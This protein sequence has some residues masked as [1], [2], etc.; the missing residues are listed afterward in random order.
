[1]NELRIF[2]IIQEDLKKFNLNL[3]GLKVLTEAATGYFALTPIIAALAG[4]ERVFALTKDSEF[5][6]VKNVTETVLSL[7][8]KCNVG[9]KIEILLSRNDE[10]IGQADIVT[11]L[12]FV[13][14]ID[15]QFI[16]RL[17]ETVVIPLMWESWE[18]R[19]EDLDIVECKRRGIPV[20]GTNEHVPELDTFNYVGPLAVKLAFELEIEVNHSNVIV[21]GSG[22]FGESTIKSFKQLG[23]NVTNVQANKGDR[24]DDDWVLQ[25]IAKSDLLVFVESAS[26]EMLLGECGQLSFKRLL[27][28][29]P[30]ISIVH[31]AG[32]IDANA[33]ELASIPHRPRK[34]AK[35][36]HMSATVDYLGPKPL[37]DLHIAGLKVGEAMAKA[38]LQGLSCEET[39]QYALESAPA[40]RL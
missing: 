8:K 28:V 27:Q 9:Q 4:A 37:I 31:V 20:M 5:G 26:R 29:N 40:M 10:T 16:S 30:S 15:K 39:M 21:V 35:V 36:G 6:S 32:Y 7:A 14:P 18:F 13:R 25:D 24:L 1:M 34:I 23:A 19:E 12:G 22:A 11:N 38:R 33:V 3:V 2:R 17:K